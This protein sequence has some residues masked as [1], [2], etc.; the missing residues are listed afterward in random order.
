VVFNVGLDLAVVS[1]SLFTMMVI[2]TLVTTFMTAPMLRLLGAPLV[3]RAEGGSASLQ[4]R[5]RVC[6]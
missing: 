5:S 1:P 4:R 6:P 2:M 3:S